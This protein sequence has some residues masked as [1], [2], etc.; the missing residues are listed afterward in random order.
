MRIMISTIIVVLFASLGC[1]SQLSH[2][3]LHDRC[4]GM[5]FTAQQCTVM[6]APIPVAFYNPRTRWEHGRPLADNY[7]APCLCGT[8]KHIEF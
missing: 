2:P 4:D 6:C 8:V 5:P 7:E 3:C 1:E